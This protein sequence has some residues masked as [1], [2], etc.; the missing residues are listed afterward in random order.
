ACRAGSRRDTE[1]AHS[2]R[3]APPPGPRSHR[4]A[5]RPR[6]RRRTRLDV[7]MEFRTATAEDVPQIVALVESAYRGDASRAGWTTEADLLEGQRTDPEGVA[8]IVASRT[9]LVLLAFDDRAGGGE[10]VGCC[11]LERHDD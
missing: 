4:Q 7:P 11:Q 6:R 1:A 2:P 8:E 3:R 5:P 10:L 9:G